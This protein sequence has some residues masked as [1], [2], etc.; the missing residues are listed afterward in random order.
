MAKKLPFVV[1]PKY[2]KY[3]LGNESTGV[4]E[5][6]VVGDLTVAELATIANLE[7][8]I[9]LF[10]TASKLAVEISEAEG[11]D[12]M[13][14][15]HFVNNAAMDSEVEEELLP[16]KVKYAEK[17]RVLCTIITD[18]TLDNQ[19]AVVTAIIKHRL[20]P[21]WTIADSAELPARLV[22]ELF[23]FATLEQADALPEAKLTEA[24]VKKPRSRA[25]AKA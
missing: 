14:V 3:T 12:L 24:D 1:E 23:D 11:L 22:A 4:L 25:A 8:G 18:R 21:D 19:L 16:L 10:E 6:R 13:R 2:K 9:S 17:I 5:I 15:Y 20:N 7:S